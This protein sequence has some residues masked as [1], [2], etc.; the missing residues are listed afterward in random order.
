MKNRCRPHR[1]CRDSSSS[2]LSHGV[3]KAIRDSWILGLLLIVALASGWARTTT[4]ATASESEGPGESG[5]AALR[6][7]F[8]RVRGLPY[9]SQMCGTGQPGRL[10]SAM[11]CERIDRVFR[12]LGYE[13]QPGYAY[14]KG[15][16]AFTADGYDPAKGVGYVF[17]SAGRLSDD[18]FLSWTRSPRGDV[19]GDRDLQRH[20]LRVDAKNVSQGLA[21]LA[22]EVIA[23]EGDAFDVAFAEWRIAYDAERLSMSEI[24]KVNQ[25]GPKR[26]EFI[27]IVT[28]FDPRY[29]FEW[30]GNREQ[31]D[32]ERE[33]LEQLAIE[34]DP[35]RQETLR[36][37]IWKE[38][39][40][41]ALARLEHDVRE[42]IRWARSR[43]LP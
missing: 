39:A 11:A 40:S 9:R 26:G 38:I 25:R 43:G 3:T 4:S 29:E 36:D 31:G 15:N 27:A 33:L 12:E 41:E 14:R 21:D 37:E 10:S 16:V 22:Y 5:E 42:Y 23:K 17:A 19:E 28:P 18:A 13:L 32:R 2:P 34:T 8:E 24:D 20:R 6:N 1:T 7:P 30:E 35:T